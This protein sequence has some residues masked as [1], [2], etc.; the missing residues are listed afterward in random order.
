NTRRKLTVNGNETIGF[1]KSKL[2]CYNCHKR[3]HFAKECRALRN[4]DNKHK[5]SSKRSVPMETSTPTALVS[6]DGLG[7]YDWSDQAEEGLNYV[8]MAFSSLNS[9]SKD[10]SQPKIK[11]K[12]VRPSI[13]KTEFV[14]SKQQEKTARKTV[15]QVEQ[16]RQDTHS[17]RA[18]PTDPHDTPTILQPSLSQPQK[19]QKPRK[20]KRK[21]NQV[22]QP[23]GPIESVVDEAVHKE[24]DDSLVRAA[25]TASSLEAKHDSESTR[26]EESLGEDASKQR[27]MIDADE[28]IT[29]VND[30]DKEMFDAD[31]LGGKEI[32]VAGIVFQE[33]G[34]STTTTTT[35]SSQHS[36]DKG[37]GIM[38]KEPMKSKKKDQIRLDEEAALKLQTEFNKEEILTRERAEKEQE[39]NIA[40]IETW[41]GIQAKIDDDHQL[42]E[43]F[44]AQEQEELLQTIVGGR[45]KRAKEELEQEITKKQNVKDDKEKVELK[46]LMET[47]PDEE[48]VA[49]DDIPL[50]VKSP[51]IGR[52]GRLVQVGKARYGSIRPVENMDYLLWSDMNIMFEPH[53]ED[54][55]WKMQLGYKGLEWKPYDF[56]GV[57]SLM[58]QSMQI[59]MLVEKKYPLTPP[60][61]SMM[62]EKSFKLIMKVKWL[63]SIWEA[64][65]EN[66]RDLNSIWKETGQ[67]CNF[68]R[69]G[70]KNAHTVHG[71]GVTIHSDAIRTYK[72]QRQK[73]G[74]GIRT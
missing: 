7:G 38:I 18:M 60:T 20:P 73:L 71:D 34:K 5:E 41:D 55:V 74:D 23:S 66:T 58:M 25:S 8:L 1:D 70:F 57:H 4:Q 72:Q 46:K 43:I 47:I 65:G 63:I 17:P 35:I 12:T 45:K 15:K 49:I 10:V 3:G 27:R 31:D 9:D 51:R 39:A 44:L 13:A 29:L 28:D 14:K 19:T 2:E 54:E 64:L 30:V 69:S 53:V 24:L 56:C 16:H 6:C 40:L 36:Q 50:A 67:D 22:P 68:T 61:L 21:D 37:K 11:N 52:F 59:Y 32:F 26:D 33:P 48:E 42:A 62:L